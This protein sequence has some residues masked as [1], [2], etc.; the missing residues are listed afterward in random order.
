MILE[1]LSFRGEFC[2]RV[3]FVQISHDKIE[4]LILR[5]FCLCGFRTISD[6]QAPL[7]PDYMICDLLS[8][9][10][11]EISFQNLSFIW[12]ENRNK[13]ILEW[14][15]REQNVI[16]VSHKQ[17]RTEKHENGTNSFQNESHSGILWAAPKPLTFWGIVLIVSHYFIG[18]CILTYDGHT[19]PVKSVCWID[20][21][22]CYAIIESKLTGVWVMYLQFQR[23]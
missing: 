5:C 8:G 13:L 6:T 9:T 1:W 15:V 4:Q 3:K 18:T 19:S 10:K 20:I 2:S 7:I 23:Q 22:K 16:S 11:N 14:L 17:I 12:N 21:G